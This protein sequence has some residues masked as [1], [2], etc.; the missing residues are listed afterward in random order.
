M[1][2][3]I[4]MNAD[5]G[6]SFGPWRM[7]RDSEMLQIV[8]SANIACGFHAGDP[9]EM[10]KTVRMCHARGIG[11][12]A[13]PGF[14]DLEGFGRRQI[15]GQ[16]GASLGAM[17]LYQIGALQAIAAAEGA[18]VSHVKLHGA[19]S[20]MCMTDATMAGAIF[21]ALRR[22]SDDLAILAVAETEIQRVAAALGG[23]VICEVFADRSYNDDGTLVARS[24]PG[25]VIHDAALAADHVLRMVEEQAIT[26]VNGVKI[27]VR[28]Q[29][30]CV[31]GDEESAVR[32]AEAVRARLEGAGIRIAAFYGSN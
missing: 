24:Q 29:S 2:T 7:G 25:A 22:L 19:L 18:R 17:V 14:R 23:P 3:T 15:L 1:T 21:K 5:L 28:P 6:E 10:T 27:P 20:N 16:S 30:V 32:L 4:D 12:G 13:H 8:T 9:V 11:I 26:S 31:H